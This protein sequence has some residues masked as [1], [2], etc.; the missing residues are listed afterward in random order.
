MAHGVFLR[1][2]W[3][4]TYNY[5]NSQGPCYNYGSLVKILFG[6]NPRMLILLAG[7]NRNFSPKAR[8]W[9]HTSLQLLPRLKGPKMLN[10]LNSHACH[11]IIGSYRKNMTNRAPAEHFPSTDNATCNESAR[12][13]N[14][15]EIGCSWNSPTAT[16]PEYSLRRGLP[17]TRRLSALFPK[18]INTSHSWFQPPSRSVP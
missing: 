18:T 1:T 11:S 15:G 10:L 14:K 2:T 17:F 5:E 8:N 13:D 3:V 16:A 4:V 12:E 7:Y 6:K 9:G